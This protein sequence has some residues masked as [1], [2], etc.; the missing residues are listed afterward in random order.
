MVCILKVR[1]HINLSGYCN[2]LCQLSKLS[3]NLYSLALDESFAISHNKRGILGMANQGHH[4]N[5]C[6]FY[7]TLQPA[8]WMDKNSVAFGSVPCIYW[9]RL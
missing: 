4:T 7:I 2:S 1:R 6:Q 9:I 5:G 3:N 8:L